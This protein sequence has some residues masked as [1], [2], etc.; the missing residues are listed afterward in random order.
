MKRFL[1]TVAFCVFLFVFG[2]FFL[3]PS[4]Q[5]E[6]NL[7][8]NLLNLPAPP[9][10][11]SLVFQDR[12]VFPPDFFD[13][14]KPPADDAPLE[15]LL[16]YWRNQSNNYRELA[17]N[18]K[19]SE[20]SLQR[21]TSEIEGNP[22]KLPEFL[23]ILPDNTD[24]ADFVKRIYDS[25]ISRE[26]ADEDWGESV[27]RWLTF[28]SKYFSDELL[29]V[30]QKVSDTDEY[31]TNQDE[32]LALTRVDWDKARPILERLYN[33]NKQPVSQTL[34]R[35]AF[36]RHALDE[37]S[38]SD[39]EKYRSELKAV[40][41]NK[42]ATAGM[43]DLAIDALVKEKEWDGLDD[44]YSTLVEDE[45]LADLRVNGR[46]YTGLTTIMYYS[47]PEKRLE[48]ML[49]LV[50][51]V[52]PTVRNAAVRNLAFLLNDKNPEVARALLPWLE[53][54]DWAKE[55][56][57]ERRRLISALGNI[58]MPESVPGLIAV[59]NEK[60]S[61]QIMTG[62]A[63]NR[64]SSMANM[65]GSAANQMMNSN[66]AVVYSNAPAEDYFPFRAE[67][68]T[69]LAKQ[70]D[71]RA[72]APL[73]A[74]LPEIENWQIHT[75]IRAL[76]ECGG[77]SI[78][79]Q[80]EALEFIAKN[81]K[82][83][84]EQLSTGSN[85]AVVR[86]DVPLPP[87]NPW[88]I[89]NTRAMNEYVRPLFKPSDIKPILG[90]QLVNQPEAD[91][92]LVAALISRIGILDEK[93]P[94]L[95]FGLRKIMQNWQGAAI[96]ALLLR[97]LKNDKSDT[98]AVVKLLSLRKE[99]RNNQWNEVSDIRGGGA[100]ALG[101]AA[102]LTENTNEYDALLRSENTEAKTAML[103]CARLIRAALP[104]RKVAENLKSPNKMLALAAE[105]Y[106]ETE[107]SPEAQAFVLSMHP[108]EAKILGAKKLFIPDDAPMTN[109]SF[110][111]ALFSTLNESNFIQNY[112]YL[113]IGS[114]GEL[115]ANEKILQREIKATQELMG[116]Y[117]YDDNF[118]RI[119]KDRAIF[120]WQTDK[121]RY[122]ERAL[123]KE[124]FD[125]F[126]A[127]LAAERV[128]EMP[129]FISQCR[130]ECQEKELLMLGRNGG[131]R[132]FLLASEPPRFFVELEKILTNLRQPPAKLR[133]A[134]EK[135]VAGLEILF[136]DE[137]LQAEAVWKNGADFRVLLSDSV[138]REQIDDELEKL[139]A[140][141]TAKAESSE[142]GEGDENIWVKQQKRRAQ[143]EFE[144]FAWYKF[145]ENKFTGLT[146][147]PK[148][149]E[150]IPMPDGAGVR[151]VPGQWKARTATFE[152]RSDAEGLYK[153][154]GSRTVKIRDGYYDDSIVTTPNG[155]W[156]I[157]KK[158]VEDEGP[159]I[160]R[161]NL[162]TKKEFPVESEEYPQFEPVVYIPTINKVLI[163]GS[164]GY[165]ETGDTTQ[166]R[167]EYFF[168]DAETGAIQQAKGEVRPLAQ[169]TFRPL[170]SNGKPDEFW[171]A[172]PD[173]G[174][175][176]TNVGIYN[177]KTL[178]F[179]SIL[180]LPQIQFNSMQMWIDADVIYF[181][182]EGHLLSL[183]LQP[184]TVSPITNNTN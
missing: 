116:V 165:E 131:R 23:N 48:K 86:N 74:I 88:L 153:I 179:K 20:R 93:D 115:A 82:V 169:Q 73:R 163:F 51:S 18:I 105:R 15:E 77:F 35:W 84:N 156:A 70:K 184:K 97:D 10:P 117:A 65:M 3:L 180:K 22:E 25:Q 120:S 96:N 43:R 158:Y 166:R 126:K 75:V 154:A 138:R 13:K 161:V 83:E 127:Y 125:G 121:A 181:V 130:E 61:R 132:I 55:V 87:E 36:Y 167:G 31:V 60:Q 68:I 69:A 149:A 19:P 12:T 72:I 99:L 135:D 175:N 32:L 134:M 94:P 157:A 50:K 11:D 106:L 112:Y 14:S 164:F 2:L 42:S 174:K 8:Q 113:F 95:A 129:Q 81:N 29:A 39:I 45:T 177:A 119:Y 76:L 58:E 160:F 171:A 142:E 172:I 107:D 144:N 49:Q 41:E 17:Y 173:A 89:G 56:G 108:N 64:M 57:G 71:A 162:T 118:I 59:L 182:Y 101:I 5:A 4:T 37:D 140:E 92:N 111:P 176:E 44:W 114:N 26:D 145:A 159:A 139:D 150:Y 38:S 52:N 21:I 146:D 128:N 1:S 62:M 170:Q 47:P 9:S 79:E 53:N 103:A 110:L 80:I 40:V 109:S 98:D 141:E 148:Q 46:S 152:M 136:A 122:H 67:A 123:S 178:A 124:E 27:R 133:Y 100:T 33:D 54:A 104:V 28:H 63:A 85:M 183:P 78:P 147:Q 7:L 24:T 91:E 137:N 168:L 34:A 155:R 143:R 102:C 16:A 6:K 66:R 30:A 151:A 90:M